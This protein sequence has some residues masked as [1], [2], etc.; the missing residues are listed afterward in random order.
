MST[1]NKTQLS[2]QGPDVT[3]FSDALHAITTASTASVEA[4]QGPLA[5]TLSGKQVALIG[6]RSNMDLS[7]FSRSVA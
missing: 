5:G 4:L 1:N 2:S 3:A 7:A 6:C